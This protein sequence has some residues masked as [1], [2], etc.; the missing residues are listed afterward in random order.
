[1]DGCAP[2]WRRKSR[3]D[4]VHTPYLRLYSSEVSGEREHPSTKNRDPSDRLQ[5]QNDEFLEKSQAIF[6]EFQ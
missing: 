3:T 5:K 6:I 1:M 4:L 2:R